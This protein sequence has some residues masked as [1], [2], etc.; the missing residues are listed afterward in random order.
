MTAPHPQAP[1]PGTEFRLLRAVA[2]ATVCV[3]LSAGGHVLASHGAVPLWSLALGFLL[4]LTAAVPFAGRARSSAVISG[5]LAVGQ[6]GLHCLF[7]YGQLVAAAPHAEH[8]TGASADQAEHAGLLPDL[9]M[10][11]GHLL[12]ALALG[13]LLRLGDLAVTRLVDLSVHGAEGVAQGA[14]V[15]AL[16]AALSLVRALHSGLPGVPAPA[17]TTHRTTP[18]APARPRV[19]ALAHTVIRRGPPAAAFV[20]AA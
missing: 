10:L 13:R 6:L 1:R 8:L 3:A 9:P 16:R 19:T 5:A 17:L 4:S 12:A 20:P 18:D 7:G 15:R 11:T 14:L 2:F